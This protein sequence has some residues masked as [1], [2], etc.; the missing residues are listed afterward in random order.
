[1]KSDDFVAAIKNGDR[2]FGSYKDLKKITKGYNHAIEAHHLVP[3]ALA[4]E[5]G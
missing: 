1:M 3:Q 2:I 5:L 4:N